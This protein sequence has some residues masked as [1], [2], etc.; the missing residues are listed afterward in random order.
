VAAAV[1][2]FFERWTRPCAAPPVGRA[3]RPAARPGPG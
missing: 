2:E 1:R 3:G